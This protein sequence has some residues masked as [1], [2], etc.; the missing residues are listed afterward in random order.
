ML[1]FSVFLGSVVMPT[2]RVRAALRDGLL[3]TFIL[4]PPVASSFTEMRI[5]PSPTYGR[6]FLT[7]RNSRLGGQLL[8][9][10]RVRLA[11][12]RAVLLDELLGSGF[13]LLRLC[14]GPETAF[15]P[16]RSDIWHKLRTRLV[17]ILPSATHAEPACQQLWAIDDGQ[18]TRFLR[19]RQD[20]FL[21]VR[22]D[23][24]VY[25]AFAPHQEQSFVAAL[26]QWLGSQD[27]QEIWWGVD[28]ASPLTLS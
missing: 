12:G 7:R 15:Q 18:L 9:Q 2:S 1:R 22:P 19:G 16:L 17:C 3:R 26:R 6:G 25:G 20:L 13:A 24:Y 21:L 23:R 28:S 14:P 8:P 27:E 5:K 4:L 11:D 10:P